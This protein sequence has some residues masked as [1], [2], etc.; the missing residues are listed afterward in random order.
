MPIVRKS[1]GLLVAAATLT[2][3]APGA[4]A[5]LLPF[6]INPVDLGHVGPGGTAVQVDEIQ[7]TSTALVTQNAG[8]QT[9]TGIAQVTLLKF[10]GAPITQL[11]DG[12]TFV[13]TTST[14]QPNLYGLYITFSATTPLQNFASQGPVTSFNFSLFADPLANDALTAA[15]AATSTAPSIVDPTSNDILLA[16]GTLAPGFNQ[17]A[18]FNSNGGP[19]ID[20]TTTFNL[21]ALGSLYF[22]APVPFYNLEFTTSTGSQPGNATFGPSP[23]CNPTPG[24][25]CNVAAITNTLDSSFQNLPVPEP[26]SLALLGAS[27]I[28][29][30]AVGW[31][32]RKHRVA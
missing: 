17:F 10:Q 5:A 9:E 22:T 16:T 4:D 3:I 21:T 12:L 27:L 7:L 25:G 20:I 31:R 30:G 2:A 29:F 26:T 23:S 11:V 19:V 6:T 13:G 1:L 15:N 24:P 18:G 8:G 32:R 28:G 14:P